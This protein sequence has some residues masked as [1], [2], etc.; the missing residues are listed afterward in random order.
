VLVFGG[1][2]VYF[3][4]AFALRAITPSELKAMLRRT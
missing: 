4:A 3:A 1:I 2:A